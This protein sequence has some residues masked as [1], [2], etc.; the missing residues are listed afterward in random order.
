M[1]HGFPKLSPKDVI[2]HREL[3]RSNSETKPNYR[4]RFASTSSQK[5]EQSAEDFFI[6]VIL[7]RHARKLL[8]NGRLF[9]LGT[10][11]A[12]LDFHMVSWLKKE[13]QRAA[14]VDNFVQ[15]LKCLHSDFQWPYPL[16][17]SSVMPANADQKTEIRKSSESSGLSST[18]VPSVVQ[19]H[20]KESVN[21][22]KRDT[23]AGISDSGYLSHATEDRGQVYLDHATALSEQTINAMLRP[24]GFR[25]KNRSLF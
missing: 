8:T 10:F 2:A 15:A 21:S 13:S 9:D 17:L 19:P 4:S 1:T 20:M 12:Q 23:P 14:R 25:G 6:D 24:H 11:A 22:G 18:L 3:S 5:D 16:L 7:Q